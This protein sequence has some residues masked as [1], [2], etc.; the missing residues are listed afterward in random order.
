MHNVCDHGLVKVARVLGEVRMRKYGQRCCGGAGIRRRRAVGL[1]VLA[2]LLTAACAVNSGAGPSGSSDGGR[3]EW[4]RYRRTGSI[5][6]V[7]DRIDLTDGGLATISRR[8]GLPRTRQLTTAELDRIRAALGGMRIHQL[9]SRYTNP[10][11]RDGF[12]YEIRYDGATV[13]CGDGAVPGPVAPVIA[14]L[15][16]LLT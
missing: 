10:N 11:V 7:D 6:A 4:L 8:G 15:D 12:A 1:L 3:D 9:Q 16:A 14:A 13:H 5:A 2:I